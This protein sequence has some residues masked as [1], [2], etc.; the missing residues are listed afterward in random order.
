MLIEMLSRT[1]KDNRV[2]TLIYT[3]LNVGIMDKGM[4]V[5]SEEG[6]P[7]EGPLARY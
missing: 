6:V 4:F 2:I 1:I 3:F 7:Q 5:R